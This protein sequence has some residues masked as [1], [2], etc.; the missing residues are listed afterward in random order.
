MTGYDKEL[1]I[2][3]DV[4]FDANIS[5]N[6]EL[7]DRLGHLTPEEQLELKETFKTSS[8][9]IPKFM[10]K[11]TEIFKRLCK[12]ENVL[13]ALF[14]PMSYRMSDRQRRY[15]FG[16]IVVCK[17]SDYYNREGVKLTKDEIYAMDLLSYGVKPKIS[18]IKLFDGSVVDVVTWDGKTL[19]QMTN[20]ESTEFVNFILD[21]REEEGIDVP[22]PTGGNFL[23]DFI[24]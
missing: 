10:P 21:K 4:V 18:N 7:F 9:L 13:D 22:P 23:T 20:Q 8:I 12:K 11:L 5:T 16:V 19:S 6:T 24:K 15:Y 17:M 14:K 3:V 1:N 2:P